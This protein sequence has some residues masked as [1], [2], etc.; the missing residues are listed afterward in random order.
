MRNLR[1]FRLLPV[2]LLA[3]A[4]LAW[5]G[6]AHAFAADP[7]APPVTNKVACE[8]TKPGDPPS[9]WQV[10]GIGDSTIQGF[11]TSMSVNVGQTVNFKIKTPAS[12]YHIDILRLGYYG[13]NGARLIASNIK[14]TASLPQT[15]PNCL[16]NSSTGLVDCGNWNVSASWTVPSEAV[17]GLYIAH[18]V[19]NDT[20]GESQI[21]FV[22]RED[23]SHSDLVL[24]TSD[25]TWEA[26]N[27]YGGNSLYSCTVSCP[28]G[29]PGGYK[30]AYAVSYNRP[31]D[32]TLERDG[33][34]SD[35]FYAEY[36][37]IRFLERNGYNMSY[38]SGHDL[39]ENPSLLQNH[40]VVISSGHDEYW[41]PGER[42]AVES[43]RSAG[44]SLA[45]FSGNEMFWKT[46]WANSSEGSN[47]PYRTLITYKDTHFPTPVDPLGPSVTT[48]TWRDPRFS[49][50]GDAGRPE[51]G[52][53][54]QN[55][56]VNSGTSEIKVPG[57]FANLR[58]WR[59]TAVSTLTAGQTL[60]LAP[61]TGTLG[62]EWDTNP[63]N[64]FR[65][66]GRISLS[67]TT[68]TGV[69]TFTDYGTNVQGGTTANHSLSLYRAPSGALV[70]GSGTVQWSWGLDVTNA[71]NSAGPNGTAPDPT[72]QQ[73]TVNLLADM[74]AQPATLQSGL[75]AQ[76]A[77]TDST[78]PTATVTSPSEGAG[79]TDGSSTTISGTATDAGGG[80]VAAVEVSTDGGSTWHT[81][82]GTSSW[83]YP[84]IVHGAPST[85]IKARA[86][87]DSGNI[88]S[89]SAAR[90][91]SVSCPCSIFSGMTPASPDSQDGNA[92]ELGVKF[93]SDVA[94][95][96]SGIRYYKASTNTGTHVGSLWT[97]NGTLLA[98]ANFS[99]ETSSGWQQVNFSSPV[100]IQA[101]TTY[102]AGYFAPNG[103]YSQTEFALEKPPALGSNILDS[104]PLHVLPNAGNGNGVYQYTAS[105]T[106]P[107][108]TY[109]SENYWVDVAFTPTGPTQPPG[110]VTG[111]TATAGVAQATVNWTPPT[112]GG[113]VASYRI[114]PYIGSTAQ[115]PTTV[116]APAT[117][118]TI[119]GLTG[120]TTYT[121]T[122]TANNEKG[123]GPESAASNAVTPTIPNP[124]GA[125]T[126]VSATAGPLRATV[127]WTAPTSDGGSPITSYR[128]TPYIGSS[129]QSPTTVPAPAGS[130]TITGLTGGTAYTFKVAAINAAGAGQDSAASNAVTPTTPTAP[131]APTGVSAEAGGLQ[132]TVTWTA[133]GSDGGSAITSYV[134]IP[135]VGSTAQTPTTV[136]P[137]STSKTIAGLTS[138][139]TY[140]FKV[141]AVNG[142]GQG[143]ES[144]ASN[145]VTPTNLAV[146]QLL[147]THQTSASTSIS[148]PA[149]STSA[150]GELL[151]AFITSDGPSSG[152]QSFSS[153]TG[154]SLTWRLRR[155][156]NTQA[157]TSEIWQ[158]NAATTLSN[159]TVTATRS[160]GSYVGSIAVAAI[161][162]A[163]QVA[164]GATAGGSVAT[165]APSVS[166]TTTRAGSWVWGVGN[167]WDNATERTIGP[168]QTKVDEFLASAGDTFWV[169]RQ[170]AA[171]PLG[172]TQVTLND[173]AP[174]SD[175]WN[176][177]AVE[178]LP[179][180][181]QNPPPPAPTLTSTVPASPAN[182][183]SPKLLGSA[184]AGSQVSIYATS[185][186][187]GT[188]LATGTAAELGTGITVT[189]ADNSTTAM[190][191]TATA[192][193]N[194]SACSSP[195]NYVEDSAA[196]QT[197][198]GTHPPALSASA[199]A[200][201]EFSGEDPGGSGVA[202]LQCRIDSTEA[203]AWASC[204]SPKAYSGLADGPHRFEARAIDAAGNTDAS[205]A[206]FEWQID[207]TPP[208]AV[209]DAGPTGTTNDSTPTFEFHSTESGS[210]FACSIDTGTPNFG[211]CSGPGS[212]HTPSALAD[213][214][215]TFRVRATDAAGN[216]GAPATRSFTINTAAPP[217][218]TLT[219][220]VPA[221]PAN[222]NSPKLLGSAA[223]G[224]QVSIY[225]TSGCTGTPLAT[226][227][228]AE[229]GTGITVTVADNSTTAM[230]ATAT[231]AGNT[232]ACSSPLNYVEDSAAPET[233]ITPG[234]TGTTNNS[235][236][237]FDF[238][239]TEAGSSFECRFDAD[240]FGPCSGPGRPTPRHC[241][242]R[243]HYTFQ[244]RATDPAGNVDPTPASRSFTINTAIPPAPTL[245][246]TVPASPANQ[247]SPKLLGSAAAGSQVSIYATSGCTGTP[248][249]TGTAAELG[250]GITV[251]VADNSTTAMRA[252]A[253]A[254]GN[255]SACS[256]PLNYVE[257]SAAPET[258]ITSGPTG[259]TNNS[260]PTFGFSSSEA[261]SSF[262]CRF[263]ADAFAPCSGP[264]AT[265][266]PSTALADGEHVFEARAT[267][268]A[269]NVDPTPASRSFT[270]NTAIPPAPTLTST[271]PASPAN[272]NSPKLLGS[273][274]AGSQVSIYATSGCTGTPLATGTAAE[275]GT[276]ITVTVADNSTTAMRATATAAGNTSA[277]SSPL[278]YVEDS[279]AP[280]TTITSGPTGTTNNS[281]P[282]FGF[283]SSEAGSS[284]ECRFDADAFAPCSG[285][286]A[287]HTP[288]T[289]LADG[290]H[291]F[292]A[293]ATDQAGNVDPTPASRSFT[294]NTAIPPAPTLT[295]TVPASPANQ[296]SPKL[297]GSAA[298]GSQVS[299][300]ATSGCTG[301]PLATG[302]AAEL[303]T[304][305]TVTVADNST[306]AMRATATAAG[307]TSACS[308]PLN[309]VEDSAA[310][311]TLIGT[312][313]PALSAS[314]AASFE[315]SGEDPGGSGVASLQC[316][317]D[318][319]E[320]S[321][322]AAC[323][324][325]KAYSGLAD[326]PHRFEARAID[327]AGN[328]D[329]S[330]AAFEWQIDTTPPTAVIDAGP[331]G[332][333]ND[334]TP[335]FEFHS[336]ESGSTFA[337]SIDTG[338][339]NFGPCSGPGSTHTPSA[340][341]DGSYTFRVRATDAAGNQGAPATRSF[342]VAAGTPPGAPTGV[343][344]VAKSSGAQLS[345]T[346]PTSNGSSP[347]TG[348]RITPFIGST[349]Q[350]PTTTGSSA[351]SASVSGLTN[352][353][354]YTFKVA[355]INSSGPGPDSTATAAV[356]PYDT[357]FDLATPSIVDAGDAGAV[358]LGVKFRSDLSGTVNGI[359]FYK[360]STNTGTHVGSLWSSTGTLL[361]QANFS[362]ETASGWQQVKFSSPVTIQA[363]TTYVA[364]YLAPKGHYSANGPTLANGLDNA[365]LHAIANG[366]SANGV[367]IYGTTAR[368]P[369][370]TFQ[371]SNYWVDVL[372]TP[373][374][375]AQPPG[376]V[377]SVSAT[378]GAQQA[379]VSWTPPAS[380][381][382]TITSY[383]IT[384]YLGST[385]QATTTA[386]APATSKA[387]TGLTAGIAYTF[388][389]TAINSA[390]AGPESA[391]SN[392]VT[393]LAAGTPEPPAGVTAEARNQAALVSWTPGGDGGS[394]IT[395]YRITPFIGSTAQSPTTTG[396]SGTSATVSGLENGTSYTFTVTALNA[397]GP[398]QA[399]A[400]SSAVM[401]RATIFEQ[402]AP[403][404]LEDTDPNS[405]ELG[406]KFTSD[407]A[408]MIR[409]VRFYKSVGNIGPHVVSLWNA[410][411]TLLA[412]ATSNGETTS[413]WQEVAFA[414]PVAIAANTTYVAG[415]LAP[416]GHY[417]ATSQA[418]ETAIDNPPLH[419]VANSAGAN[420]V[421]AYSATS[422]FPSNTF[423]AT[424]YWVDVLFTP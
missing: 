196:P 169:Q 268:Q 277:C 2:P 333:T 420:G 157:G 94:G 406:V 216:Q 145:P 219:S 281:T 183:N 280:E 271:V 361:A 71:W 199:A 325:P 26:Y 338:T 251:T 345:W 304:G 96:I 142:I 158:A 226:G 316:R 286:G 121:F 279:A 25:T 188:P 28:P 253:T 239:S 47:T 235:T 417:S 184:A 161:S 295:S 273:A 44:V 150:P 284:F 222:Q 292:E 227:T 336:T 112:T 369:T 170:T 40:K 113:A 354:A 322:W 200:S 260:T 128:V 83:T 258:T 73:A 132:A 275:L 367:Y 269:G 5:L 278:N 115:T 242:R 155:R 335:T 36:Q 1:A 165:G 298:A 347:I 342:T 230:R 223:A 380:E 190:R 91:V 383:R 119:A 11:A 346:A 374:A 391:K 217:A 206:A 323:T 51:N 144:A 364:G 307:N 59:N 72:M 114:T 87:D 16:T 14:P 294:V 249:A 204:T 143:P 352:G 379:T 146:D 177:A 116:N 301:T 172:G 24:K 120:G 276:G 138:G 202:S 88:G 118:K 134:V 263:D 397:I 123:S 178:V 162:G 267:D 79:L 10:N 423:N 62:Y 390:G 153:V 105:S 343:T 77:S 180:Q 74:G 214:S 106:F 15:Q 218:P 76:T 64:G 191:A 93:R 337:C 360:A 243:W 168:N 272:Q 129:P 355:A 362:G 319:T 231:A 246:S 156:A 194:T 237:T 248:L 54:G 89:A 163:D 375:A 17:S 207:T 308:S 20:G 81:A 330:P 395:G 160:S 117:S 370:N 234:P 65:P 247:N 305:I 107:Q 147:T 63:D 187:T 110:P 404:V 266:T 149:F 378:A 377:T 310:P 264:G 166:L 288:S 376:Q 38:V 43:A 313:P 415:Y 400:A 331:T 33:G 19:R 287:T 244:A 408:G 359:R 289:A 27:A 108:N 238:P 174:T 220:T 411:G 57:T 159:A 210:T 139:T 52:V 203:S 392:S 416:G 189:V 197:L 255:T 339:P 137:P 186:C 328:T 195:L 42:Q 332:T 67:S 351:T 95:Q 303:G 384:P 100:A 418:F 60:T 69:E 151:L 296:N 240:A 84:W 109:Q 111:V 385:A 18:L 215:Y 122:V 98:Q 192:A 398:G 212:T 309:Y 421:Y 356:T 7:C 265:H 225:A 29:N 124:P 103:H 80:V 407:M 262:E 86:V 254:A 382:E 403:A 31:F 394:Q 389:V 78:P 6:S 102:V 410:A 236:P 368:F 141:A 297:L 282:T 241:A 13:G 348:Y 9:D 293:R 82:T 381:A 75:V 290:E 261:G 233:L 320:A 401:P 35:P 409:G 55:F 181:T 164:E 250:T 300:Y 414:S 193:G 334:S 393:P 61:G 175:R 424:N 133:P 90:T 39:D 22:V 21:F 371:A 232:S 270:V 327:A 49:P 386:S 257:D 58:F 12:S 373:T 135:Y 285:P 349:A 366:T 8:N 387:V 317:I 92:V 127:N 419:A 224:S 148:S 340:L 53:T 228:A 176:L 306:T 101:N 205:P 167:D 405:V 125:P 50:P 388:T 32:G 171:T 256:S 185:G 372:F 154:G 329:A 245:T 85:T 99:G 45:F 412:Q 365:P 209:I 358:E 140:T 131:G 302:T 198:I 396:S 23:S 37:L 173:T 179:A 229:L 353:T 30:A 422:T 66:P 68:V 326:G 3:V 34:F 399:S 318:S 283:S 208:T 314:A 201:F 41:S 46:R 97:S 311:Q 344:A 357:I 413:G 324:S 104:P 152:T 221:S 182:Q 56:L 130:A 402:A 312:H 70:F 363:N 350:S 315:F 126:G 4:M 211:P 48:S 274:A 259:T 341:A 252:T 213:G 321:A 299:I 291:V 136:N